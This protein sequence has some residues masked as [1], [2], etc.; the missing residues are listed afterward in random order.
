MPD[1]D[2][3]R[4]PD[5]EGKIVRRE[6]H[7]SQVLGIHPIFPAEGHELSAYAHIPLLVHIP[8]EVGDKKFKIP[9]WIDID[10]EMIVKFFRQCTL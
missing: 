5:G 3:K 6:L 10:A 7:R 2:A 4:R 8:L 9:A 1:L